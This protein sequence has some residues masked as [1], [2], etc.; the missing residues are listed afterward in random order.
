MDTNIVGNVRLGNYILNVYSSLDEPLFKASEIAEF[1]GYSNNA[2]KLTQMCEEDERLK[3]PMVV[4]GQRREILFVTEQG[5][6][7]ILSHSNMPYARK[8]RR[9]VLSELIS[10][11]KAKDMT[12]EE[13]FDEWAKQ[14]DDIYYDEE[15]GR[16]MRTVT[17]PGGDVE[18]VPV[19]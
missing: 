19:T 5:L 15:T 14:I 3:L 18:Q 10:L 13:Q 1:I 17:V 16:L 9:I 12:I 11:R 8:W 7:N 2:W 4:A 6:Y